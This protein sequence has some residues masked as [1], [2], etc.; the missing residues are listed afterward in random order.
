MTECANGN[1]IDCAIEQW[2]AGLPP[3]LI[4]VLANS[5]ALSVVAWLSL[6]V[7][8]SG[9]AI[10][11]AQIRKIARSSD[12]AKF[13][14]EKALEEVSGRDHLVEM[15]EAITWLQLMRSHSSTN[16]IEAALLAHVV[17]RQKIVMIQAL[18]D[19]QGLVE[20][21]LGSA[22]E[23]MNIISEH[24]SGL[25]VS[26]DYTVDRMLIAVNVDKISDT[27]TEWSTRLRRGPTAGAE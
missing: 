11:V 1:S 22:L 23:N 13:A 10:A 20:H 9:F 15:A 2:A 24:L 5:T 8:V 7:T 27:L 26:G 4:G 14:A 19:R 17:A 12:A 6:I 21:N 3:V 25:D 16:N 18:F